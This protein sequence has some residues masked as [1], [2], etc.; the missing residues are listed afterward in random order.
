VESGV[1]SDHR[2]AIENEM[3]ATL[4]KEVDRLGRS[5]R[6]AAGTTILGVIGVGLAMVYATSQLRRLQ[7]E[8]TTSQEKL[9]I[10]IGERDQATRE[11]DQA[12]EQVKTLGEEIKKL[13]RRLSSTTNLAQFVHPV[14]F[15]DLKF[16]ASQRPAG[17]RVLERILELR[18]R[19]VVWRLGGRRPSEGFDSPSFAAFVLQSLKIIGTSEDQAQPNLLSTLPRAGEPKVGDLVFYPGGYALFFFLDQH[20][21]PFVIGMTPQGIVALEPTFAP[22]E[23]VA[24]PNYQR[25]TQ[26]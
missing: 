26:P 23:G 3:D 22:I 10:I 4:E 11:R 15:V 18:A 19:N 17:A 6:I 9:S 24:H 20:H 7:N 25:Q 1:G 21:R 5:S 13:E 2:N 16:L 8:I 14:D 12:T